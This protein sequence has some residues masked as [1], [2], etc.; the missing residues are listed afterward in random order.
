MSS[1]IYQDTHLFACVS[2]SVDVLPAKSGTRHF[3]LSLATA[4]P[5]KCIPFVCRCDEVQSYSLEEA[6][7]CA[8]HGSLLIDRLIHEIAYKVGRAPKYGA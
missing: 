8:G 7:T 4:L 2:T 5:I 1:V 3:S 6:L